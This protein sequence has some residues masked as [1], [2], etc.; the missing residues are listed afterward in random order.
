VTDQIDAV[1]IQAAP[2]GGSNRRVMLGCGIGCGLL[3]FLIIV[4]IILIVVLG[5][6]ALNRMDELSKP[7][8]ENQYPVWKEEGIIKADQAEVYDALY[9]AVYDE[10]LASRWVTLCTL[11]VMVYHTEDGK[12]MDEEIEQAQTLLD[13]IHEQPGLGI[14]HWDAFMKSDE[15]F[16]DVTRKIPVLVQQ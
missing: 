6:V 11:I 1:E 5:N 16:Q 13:D 3:V 2:S 14:V 10:A 9:D 7:F 4:G 8:L 15:G 12:I